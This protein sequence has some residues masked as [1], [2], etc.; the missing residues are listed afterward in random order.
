VGFEL[1]DFPIF[2]LELPGQFLNLRGEMVEFAQNLDG[3][4]YGEWRE[5]GEAIPAVRFGIMRV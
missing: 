4:L 1:H 3:F 2:R 5:T